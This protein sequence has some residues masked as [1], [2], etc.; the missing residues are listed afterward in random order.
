[1]D[2]YFYTKPSKNYMRIIITLFTIIISNT[3]LT[4]H[5]N[6]QNTNPAYNLALYKVARVGVP[7]L[8]KEPESF[9]DFIYIDSFP[10]IA[11]HFDGFYQNCSAMDREKINDQKAKISE[12]INNG[13]RKAGTDYC[14]YMY[15]NI[16]NSVSQKFVLKYRS[17]ENCRS[18]IVLHYNTIRNVMNAA[19]RQCSKEFFDV[20]KKRKAEEE[21]QKAQEKQILIAKRNHEKELFHN[22]INTTIGAIF[23]D[24]NS[25]LIGLGDSNGKNLQKIL[26][27]MHNAWNDSL[28][29]W[30]TYAALSAQGSAGIDVLSYYGQTSTRSRDATVNFA[31]QFYHAWTKLSDE[32]VGSFIPE[33][34]GSTTIIVGNEFKNERFIIVILLDEFG[35]IT[36][37]LG[38]PYGGVGNSF[39]IFTPPYTRKVRYK[40]RDTDF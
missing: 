15:N 7:N 35:T 37:F 29:N 33:G 28:N 10:R 30:T 8:N 39:N 36:N 16:P 5:A 18:V 27:N 20:V 14:A 4:S 2:N 38:R 24:R 19:E 1:M 22:K 26:V 12:I 13:I 6:Q 17:I 34:G 11:D 23:V 40:S 9:R 25:S 31:K 3:H 21:K 32:Y